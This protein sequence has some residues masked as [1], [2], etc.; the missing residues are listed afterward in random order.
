MVCTSNPCWLV[1]TCDSCS[2]LLTYCLCVSDMLSWFVRVFPWSYLCIFWLMHQ[3]SQCGLFSLFGAL[4]FR[5]FSWCC[6]ENLAQASDLIKEMYSCGCKDK[7]VISKELCLWNI[8]LCACVIITGTRITSPYEWDYKAKN[9]AS[10]LLTQI[11]LRLLGPKSITEPEVWVQSFFVPLH[12][13]GS[14][15]DLTNCGNQSCICCMEVPPYIH[16]K[17]WQI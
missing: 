10:S 6:F 15:K 2:S 14:S 13:D 17:W 5:K 12:I 4:S 16:K 9:G 11:D 8:Q 3:Q 1:S 7:W